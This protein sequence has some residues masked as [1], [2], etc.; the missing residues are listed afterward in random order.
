MVSRSTGPDTSAASTAQTPASPAAPPVV[1]TPPTD[2]DRPRRPSLRERLTGNLGS[3]FWLMWTGWTISS[4]GNGLTVTALALL[5]ADL[6]TNAS[7]VSLVSFAGRL[8]W[9]LLALVGGVLADRW[10]RRTA[11]WISDTIRFFLLVGLGVLV[12]GGWDSI[13]VLMVV[14]FGITA[15]ETVYDS[16]RQSILPTL[17]G[18]DPDVLHSANSRLLTAKN[19]TLQFIGPAAG[20]VLYSIARS[21]PVLLDALSFALSA[22]F[23]FLIRGDRRAPVDAAPAARKPRPSMW[24]ESAEGF[25]WL[26]RHRILRVFTIV[27]GLKNMCTA[28]MLAV[29]VLYVREVMH[30]SDAEYG[31]LLSATAIGSIIGGFVCRRIAKRLGPAVSSLGGSVVGGLGFTILGFT[32]VPFLVG[33]GLAITGFTST[34]WNVAIVSLRQTLVPDGLNG[35]INGVNRL[36]T[37]GSMPL[38]ILIGGVIADHWGLIRLY[39]VFGIFGAAVALIGLLSLSNRAIDDA[40]QGVTSPAQ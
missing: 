8:P 3:D 7:Q 38:G 14:A 35:R 30:G 20:G 28:S 15:I 10:N 21:L 11:M 4:G 32:H 17:V 12:I 19:T 24:R 16:S 23:T 33:A 2:D 34:I 31:V 22:L 1:V 40:V 37:F 6:T 29:L 9:L 27:A 39:Q 5:A 18:R 36:V 13:P 25:R 26:A